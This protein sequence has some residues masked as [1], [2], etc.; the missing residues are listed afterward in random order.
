MLFPPAYGIKVA[1]VT[2]RM[3][4]QRRMPAECP[5]RT[6]R[7]IQPGHARCAYATA[8][9]RVR[10]RHAATVGGTRSRSAIRVEDSPSAASDTIR[11]RCARPA[12]I[13]D[14]RSHP[15]SN[16][17]SPA[18]SAKGFD[19]MPQCP[20]LDRKRLKTRRTRTT[21]GA[22]IRRSPPTAENPGG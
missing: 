12:R 19:R 7:I 6:R 15:L 21:V 17:R 16:S 3:P 10:N 5:A 2:G 11:A 1:K 9:L 18:R 13:E 22:V 20:K 4:T 8:T 14:D